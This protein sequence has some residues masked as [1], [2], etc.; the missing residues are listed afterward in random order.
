MKSLSSF[1]G[2]MELVYL[3][4][5]TDDKETS[6]LRIAEYSLTYNNTSLSVIFI[7]EDGKWYIKD[8]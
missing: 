6:F 8:L 1:F 7:Y 2:D 4:E 5:K 3:S